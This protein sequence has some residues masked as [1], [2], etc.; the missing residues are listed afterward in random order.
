[1]QDS[2]AFQFTLPTGV[3][4]KNAI[5]EVPIT[6]HNGSVLT[7]DEMTTLVNNLVSVTIK[8]P[9]P[10]ENTAVPVKKRGR[11]KK[12]RYDDATGD[13]DLYHFIFTCIKS[14]YSYAFTLY[15][16]AEGVVIYTKALKY[17][18]K[19][20][21]ED[22]ITTFTKVVEENVFDEA[23]DPLRKIKYHKVTDDNNLEPVDDDFREWI[24]RLLKDLND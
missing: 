18:Y 5:L 2:H 9:I 4:P 24:I 14:D 21:Y 22:Y 10:K 12:F 15:E 13:L 1:M 7:P 8:P 17:G 11:P 20:T 6:M 23:K 3:D 19:G 16:D